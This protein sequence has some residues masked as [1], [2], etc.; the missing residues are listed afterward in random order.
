MIDSIL[1]RIASAFF[2]AFLASCSDT[3]PV[4][5]YAA[6][7]RFRLMRSNQRTSSGGRNSSQNRTTEISWFDPAD[8]NPF[9][10]TKALPA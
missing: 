9:E 6:R 8:R 1:C 7:W 4:L 2:T 3:D 10:N 5:S